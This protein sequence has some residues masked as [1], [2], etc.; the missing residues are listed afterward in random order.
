MVVH[1]VGAVEEP[2]EIVEAEVERDGQPDGGPQGVPA[3]HPVPEAE[4]V[5][6]VDAEFRDLRRVGGEGDKVLRHGALVF[7]RFQE[8]E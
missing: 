6:G 3:A 7:R 5:L 2:L 4:H 8:P 1:E